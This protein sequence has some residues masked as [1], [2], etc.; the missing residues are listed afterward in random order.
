M[1][2][3]TLNAILNIVSAISLITG[4]IF[5][6]IKNIRVH[7]ICGITAFIVS[8]LF[9]IS[10]LIYHYKVGSTKFQGKGIIRQF[11]FAILWS[12]TILATVTLPLSITTIFLALKSKITQHKKIAPFTLLVWLYVN[13][14][15]VIIYLMLY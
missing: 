5:I 9:L 15:G 12:H 10:Y 2:V 3:P 8:I 4:F 11:Y 7:K 1:T 14:T 13:V 6:K